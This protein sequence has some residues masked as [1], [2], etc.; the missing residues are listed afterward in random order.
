M[1]NKISEN[2]KNSNHEETVINDNTCS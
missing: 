1:G 2:M